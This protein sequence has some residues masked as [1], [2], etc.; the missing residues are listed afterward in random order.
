M[1]T[2]FGNAIT[3]PTSTFYRPAHQLERRFDVPPNLRL[4]RVI[5]FFEFAGLLSSHLQSRISAPARL[6][7][8]GL[9]A[10][11]YKAF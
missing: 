2:A 3:L 4:L 6:S 11:S 1:D 8:A 10:L 9:I 7:S 5:L